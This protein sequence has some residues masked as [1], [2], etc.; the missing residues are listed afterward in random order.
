MSK[1]QEEY[2]IANQSFEDFILVIFVLVD[3][4]YKKVAP[5][6]VKCRPNIDKALLSDSEIITIALCG[7]LV[8]VDSENAWYSLV[9][10]NF[11]YLFPRMCDRSQFNRTRRNLLQVT[12]LIFTQ[13]AKQFADDVFIVDSF[14]LE[15]CKFGRAHFCKV[16]RAEGATYGKNPSKKQ[17]YF[18]F[19]VH[20]I[21][22]SGGAVKAFEITSANVDDRKGLEDLSSVVKG[23]SVILADKGYVSKSLVGKIKGQGQTLLVLKRNNARKPYSP[24]LQQEIFRR[25]RRIETT[26]SQMTQQ[27]NAQR[28]LAKTFSGLSLRLLTKFLAFNLCM[29]L[30]QSSQIKSFIF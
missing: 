8:G 5:N 16:F 29:L 27:L 24:T 20:A 14:P 6:Q 21:T 3:D 11:R 15:V 23:G 18:G 17:T 10:K 30:A 1:F 25:R 12:N 26:F 19:K 9:K 22:T 13:L 2:S 7:E 28:V 4:L